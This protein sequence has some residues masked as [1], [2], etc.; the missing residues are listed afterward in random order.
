MSVTVQMLDI[1]TMD[2]FWEHVADFSYSVQ[3]NLSSRKIHQYQLTSSL[4]LP[5]QIMPSYVFQL[6]ETINFENK[7]KGHCIISALVFLGF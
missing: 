5:C 1:K 7:R 2:T 3:G 6:K 4:C